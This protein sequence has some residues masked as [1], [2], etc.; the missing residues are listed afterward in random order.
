MQREFIMKLLQIGY[1]KTNLY[2]PQM[3]VD[4]DLQAQKILALQK[5]L[6][7]IKNL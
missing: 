3:V 4:V 2:K 5:W 6:L 7:F 1:V